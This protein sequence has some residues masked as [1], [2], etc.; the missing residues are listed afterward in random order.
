MYL[1]LRVPLGELP[2]RS[3]GIFF[4]AAV[5][6]ATEVIP[7]YATSFLVV[8]G[9][10]LLLASDGGLADE[11]TDFVQWIGLPAA[12]Q[13]MAGD[14]EAVSASAFLAPVCA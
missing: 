14:V 1:W 5:C 7:L 8:A 12:V 2:A 9:E 10:I 3:I 13:S 6:W 11:I 4:F